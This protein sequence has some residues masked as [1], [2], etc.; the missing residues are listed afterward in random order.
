MSCLPSGDSGTILG[1]VVNGSRENAPASGA[2]VVLQ[3]RQDEAFI[4][5][6]Q[7]TADEQGRFAFD[8]LSLDGDPQFLVGANRDGVFHPGGR[9][10]LNSRRAEENVVVRVFDAITEPSPLI[11]RRHT[12]AIRTEPNLLNVTETILISNPSVYCYV[13]DEGKR[14]VTLRLSVPSEFE[15]ITF[16]KEFYGRRFAVI[17]GVLM[18][19]IPWPP[20]ERELSFT[21]VVP[22]EKR[23]LTWERPLDLPCGDVRV[24]IDTT[25]PN[26]ITSTLPSAPTGKGAEL[27]FEHRG[28]QLPAG[29]V[30]RVE[31]GH[32]PL[33]LSA[34]GR[35][36]ALGML[37]GSVLVVTGFLL[38]RTRRTIRENSRVSHSRGLVHS[39]S[40]SRG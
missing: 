33:S 35:W 30:I 13:G 38:L 12:V 7:T 6:S 37:G 17:D 28:V 2:E 34:D 36:I 18:T 32:Q 24:T 4:P 20:G 1:T 16:H 3:V 25:N 8:G 9:V 31:L 5:L 22:M 29:H 39:N 19:T 26:G 23:C 40:A 15:K 21:Y 11:A 14:S 27:V 10:R